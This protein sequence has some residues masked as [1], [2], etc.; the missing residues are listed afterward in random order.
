MSEFQE[1]LMR[2]QFEHMSKDA[3]FHFILDIQM[4]VGS[5]VIQ[6]EITD[7]AYVNNQRALA[8]LAGEYL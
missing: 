5:H 8:R 1:Q 6:S 4:R 3:I 2:K 7:V